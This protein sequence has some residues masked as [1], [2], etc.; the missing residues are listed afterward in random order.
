MEEPK[1]PLNDDLGSFLSALYLDSDMK[2]H[3]QV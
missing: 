2:I 1:A 3:L